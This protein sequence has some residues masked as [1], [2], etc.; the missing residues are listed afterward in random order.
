LVIG[1]GGLGSPVALYLAAAGVGNIGIVDSDSVELSNLQRQ[2]LFNNSDMGKSKPEIAKQ[3]L[4]ALNPDINVRA[5]HLR[6]AADNIMD[7]IKGYDIVIDCS[8]NFPTR[9]LVNDTCVREKKTLVHGAVSGLEG[10]VMVVKPGEGPC[11]RCLFPEPPPAGSIPSCRETGIL[12][13][14]AGLIGTVQ[15]IEALKLV[16][17]M[18]ETLAGKLLVFNALDMAFRTMKVERKKNCKICGKI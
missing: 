7:V 3:R 15:A 2:I 6:L 1:A 4:T 13:A 11:Y 12:G 10:Q 18:G 17:E 14:V 5:Y 9:Y 16:L 8:D